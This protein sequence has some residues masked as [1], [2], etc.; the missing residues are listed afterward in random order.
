MYSLFLLK[1]IHL[2]LLFRLVLPLLAQ[3]HRLFPAMRAVHFRHRLCNLSRRLLPQRVDMLTVP[4][5]L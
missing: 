2:H 1:W 5:Q 3:L 4:P